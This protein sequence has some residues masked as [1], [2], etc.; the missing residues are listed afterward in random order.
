M[1]RFRVRYRGAVWDADLM[2][3]PGTGRPVYWQLYGYPCAPNSGGAL[4]NHWVPI[5]EGA[6]VTNNVINVSNP[7]VNEPMPGQQAVMV[8]II[9]LSTPSTNSLTLS[10][11]TTGGNATPGLDYQPVS[12]LLT[13]APGET[14]K[15]V[16]VTVLGDTVSPEPQEQV[17]LE[18]SEAFTF[19][20]PA[21][22]RGTI[23]DF[24]WNPNMGTPYVYNPVRAI[25]EDTFETLFNT[26]F[27]FI[28]TCKDFIPRFWDRT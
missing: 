14:S 9:N 11:A 7:T 27:D 22:G 2:C 28:E 10:Y 4:Q 23:N 17:N 6:Q 12:G 1:G 24:P 3:E 18:V 5:A 25:V 16:S 20:P 13:F 26:T 21:I 19:D 15:S 8:Y